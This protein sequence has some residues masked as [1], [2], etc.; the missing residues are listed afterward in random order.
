VSARRA[1]LHRFYALL[2]ELERRCGGKRRLAEC[3]GRMGWPRRGVYFFFEDGEIREDGVSPRVVRVGTH[4]LRAS[5]STLWGR[6]SQHKG[7]PGGSL[8][9]GGNHRGSILRLHVGSALLASGGWPKSILSLWSVGRTARAEVRRAEYPLERAVSDHVGAMPL[10]WL[11]V[12]DPAGP[13]SDRGAI[14]TGAIALLSN[15]DREP[16]DPPSAGWLGRRAHSRLVRESGLWNVN[17]VQKP[18]GGRFLDVFAG[19]LSR[20]EA[21]L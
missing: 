4:A 16:I 11:D 1:E 18:P 3:H 13:K 10:L 17:H 19:W 12:D 20:F 7:S 21:T 5:K 15:L 8:P 14:E 9:G 2:A 6:L